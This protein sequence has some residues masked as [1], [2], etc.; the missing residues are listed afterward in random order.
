MSINRRVFVKS[1][2]MALVAMGLPPT[3]LTRSLLAET[4]RAGKKTVIAIF[5]RGAVDGLNMVVPFGEAA[6]YRVRRAIAVPAPGTQNGALDLD[7]FFGLHPALAPL[8]EIWT[9][10]E[11]AIIHAVGSPHPTRSHFDAQD[12][13]ESGTPGVKE[14]P[15][16]WL[17]RVLQQTG[18]SDCSGRTPADGAAHAADH[19]AGQVGLAT[20]PF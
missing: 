16:G 9:R 19:A 1:G 10:K 17:N 4:K 18:C 20:S 6:Y 11:M 13:M 15:D 7:G 5:Q 12:F 2:A 8:Q 3:F 14:T